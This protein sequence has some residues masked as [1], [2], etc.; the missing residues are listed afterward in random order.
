MSEHANMAAADLDHMARLRQERDEAQRLVGEMHDTF[1]RM[2]RERDAAKVAAHR[3]QMDAAMLAFLIEQAH[4]AAKRGTSPGDAL[5]ALYDA[6]LMV[7]V[8]NPGMA[9]LD[10]ARAYRA[11]VRAVDGIA[12]AE[13]ALLAAIEAMDGDLSR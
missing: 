6:M 11:A 9:L 7:A 2:M 10:A 12:D 1:A 8:K 3:F 4:A 5:Y 13:A